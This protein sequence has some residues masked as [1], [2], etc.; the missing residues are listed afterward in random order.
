MHG[1]MHN[2]T[3]HDYRISQQWRWHVPA[4]GTLSCWRLGHRLGR[5]GGLKWGRTA[6]RHCCRC[7]R[8]GWVIWGAAQQFWPWATR[9]H[10]DFG[11]LQREPNESRLA[12]D[13]YRNSDNPIW[14]GGYGH[15]CVRGRRPDHRDGDDHRQPGDA[16]EE[17]P[18]NRAT[19]DHGNLFR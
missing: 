2:G 1:Q 4:A 6:R 15:D 14:R 7:E 11:C 16:H 17:I 8:V 13:L 3:K 19:R 10:V 5:S 12:C 9:S 18:T